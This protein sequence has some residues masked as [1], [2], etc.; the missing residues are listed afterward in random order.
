MTSQTVISHVLPSY[1]VTRP[2]RRPALIRREVQDFSPSSAV[3]GILFLSI[4]RKPAAIC[5]ERGGFYDAARWGS[6]AG[7]QVTCLIDG[8]DRRRLT[9][10]RCLVVRRIVPTRTTNGHASDASLIVCG[11]RPIQYCRFCIHVI[12]IHVYFL[13]I[14]W[15]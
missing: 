10:G 12:D 2:R 13:K 11:I 8:P 14:V 15:F 5:G 3:I 9:D 6:Q 1:P 4:S 7:W